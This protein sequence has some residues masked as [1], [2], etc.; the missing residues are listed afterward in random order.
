MKT[1]TVATKSLARA[2]KL[3]LRTNNRH[4]R[5]MQVADG[6]LVLEIAQ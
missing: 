5:L 4:A 2:L 6:W 3:A 1:Y